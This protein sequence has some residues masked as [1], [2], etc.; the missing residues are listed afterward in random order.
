VLKKEVKTNFFFD[1]KISFFEL[2]KLIIDWDIG[3]RQN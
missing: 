1:D 2:E 3:R